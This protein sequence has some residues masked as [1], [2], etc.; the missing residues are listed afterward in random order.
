MIPT[1][2]FDVNVGDYLYLD[3]FNGCMYALVLS[4]IEQNFGEKWLKIE[5]LINENGISRKD[6]MRLYLRTSKI[7]WNNWR[8]IM[9]LEKRYGLVP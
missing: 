2:W 9:G 6:T 5:L 3:Y 1:C 4:R 7:P 8:F